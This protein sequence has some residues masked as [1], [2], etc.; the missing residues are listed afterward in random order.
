VG[1]QQA[2]GVYDERYEDAFGVVLG[3]FPEVGRRS[4]HPWDVWCDGAPRTLRRGKHFK[5]ASCSG[6]RSTI[7]SYA[8]Q[9]DI[10]V[11]VRLGRGGVDRAGQAA[12]V[13]Q[14]MFITLQFFPGVPYG[15]DVSSAGNRT[16][17]QIS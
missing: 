1:D 16:P 2:S 11:R 10:A 8:R 14:D 12:M 9:N 7:F 3:A 17:Q 13:R 15:E 4:K 5:A 6:M